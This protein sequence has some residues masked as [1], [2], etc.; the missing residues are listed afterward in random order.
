ML[1]SE[2]TAR[3]YI[4]ASNRCDY[5]AMSDLFHAD[6]EWIP[7][8]PIEPRRGR[9]AIRER[10]LNEVRPMNHPIINDVYTADARRCVVEFEVDHP[11]RGPVAIVDVFDV[12]DQGQITR[13]AVYRR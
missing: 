1:T 6:A 2:A 3:A 9:E 4:A 7:I 11:E 10:Y 5:D 12:D 13:L 8:A